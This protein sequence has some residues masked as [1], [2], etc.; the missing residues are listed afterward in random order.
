MG[1]EDRPE[2]QEA[3][4]NVNKNNDEQQTNRDARDSNHRKREAATSFKD[5]NP[6]FASHRKPE[7]DRKPSHAR[8]LQPQTTKRAR[9]DLHREREE[10]K[11]NVKS[12]Q[13]AE[14]KP[15][16][17]RRLEHAV[18]Q[19]QLAVQRGRATSKSVT[20]HTTAGARK[21]HLR[22]VERKQVLAAGVEHDVIG[23]YEPPLQPHVVGP[24]EGGRAVHA[25]VTSL[26]EDDDVMRVHGFNTHVSD[27]IALNRT[28]RDTRHPQYVHSSSN[29]ISRT[30]QFI[31]PI[32]CVINYRE[33]RLKGLTSV[34]DRL[35]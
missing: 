4:A 29:L 7:V 1:F 31:I 27:V 21:E 32:K 24:G 28:L 17:E 20:S 35:W 33:T 26:K 22:R 10:R 34:H 5:E 11:S 3:N 30:L 12:R 6:N 15:F 9:V 2:G 25:D 19:Y 23:N 13:E 8:V 14:V 18:K 16:D